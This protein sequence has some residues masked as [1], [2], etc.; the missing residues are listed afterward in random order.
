MP[1]PD[2]WTWINPTG[3]PGMASGGMGDVL[4][5][6]IGG[7][8]AQGY[9]PHEACQLGVFLHGTAGDLAAQG[10]GEIGML[11]RD[12]IERLPSGLR[13]LCQTAAAVESAQEC[14]KV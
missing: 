11:A 8:L 7:L 3:N 10:V 4:A 12:V 9:A 14:T 1:G 2:S 13:V 6:V 5:G